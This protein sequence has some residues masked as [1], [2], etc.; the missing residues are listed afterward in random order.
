MMHASHASSSNIQPQQHTSLAAMHPWKT[1]Y[2]CDLDRRH[3]M[4]LARPI[5]WSAKNCKNR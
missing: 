5:V 3:T 4:P 2:L 1:L